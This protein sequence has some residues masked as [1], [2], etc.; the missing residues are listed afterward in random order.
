MSAPLKGL[1]L[2]GGESRRMGSPKWALQRDGETQLQRTSRLLRGVVDDIYVSVRAG[3]EVE[4]PSDVLPISDA[5]PFRGPINGILSAM[6][7]D[8]DAAWLVVACDLPLLDAPTLE[9][10]AA[11]RN[12]VRIATAYESANDGL[13]E[14]LCAVWEPRSRQRL[15][16]ALSIDLRCPR[17]VLIESRPELLSLANERALD[18]ANTPEEFE[19]ATETFAAG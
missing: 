18:N 15:L 11:G 16:Q 14:P 12:P 5:L 13:P 19:Q 1:V 3:Q 9:V 6:E 7:T 10:L 17:K 8:R 4:L 2:V